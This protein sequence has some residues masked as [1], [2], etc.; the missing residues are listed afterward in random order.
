MTIF[1]GFVT[2]GTTGVKPAKPRF[3]PEN[4]GAIGEGL[5]RNDP[6]AI[7][8]A[9]MVLARAGNEEA[10]AG[11]EQKL[12]EHLLSAE[13]DAR[14]VAY[15]IRREDRQKVIYLALNSESKE[16]RMQI[17]RSLIHGLTSASDYKRGYFVDEL[18]KI[19]WN[20]TDKELRLFIMRTI[21]EINLNIAPHNKDDQTEYLTLLYANFDALVKGRK[22]DVIL[23]SSL[24][25]SA[26]EM[27]LVNYPDQKLICLEHLLRITLKRSGSI[28]GMI[29]SKL[30]EEGHINADDVRKAL[31]NIEALEVARIAD[32]Y[33]GRLV[34]PSKY[35]DNHQWLEIPQIERLK[36]DVEGFVNGDLT[37]ELLESRLKV[38]NA[39]ILCSEDKEL[40]LRIA[41]AVEKVI[42]NTK[43]DHP[44]MY[45]SFLVLRALG[46]K[47][48]DSLDR[49]KNE[50][51]FEEVRAR[52]REILARNISYCRIALPKTVEHFV[53]P[54]DDSYYRE[55]TRRNHLISDLSLLAASESADAQLL[56]LELTNRWDVI[57]GFEGV[58]SEFAKNSPHAEVRKKAL[59]AIEKAD[60]RYCHFDVN[61]PYE[62][63]GIISEGKYDDIFP[64]AIRIVGRFAR[65]GVRGYDDH[66]SSIVI[67]MSRAGLF[68]KP[69]LLK[70]ALEELRSLERRSTHDEAILAVHTES[71]QER[72]RITQKLAAPEHIG[73]GL[74]G[75]IR[76]GSQEQMTAI[77]K[78]L[79]EN[80]KRELVFRISRQLVLANSDRYPEEMV[81]AAQEAVGSTNPIEQVM[82]V[83]SLVVGGKT[84]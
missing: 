48:E 59:E 27:L 18:Q 11:L 15:F 8:K 73:E 79:I 71:E 34:L 38:L 10:K 7:Y 37:I 77:F 19:A 54:E 21:A 52:A 61:K 35:H 1:G 74:L 49:I 2:K 28:S 55:K 14:C 78:L 68:R 33:Y 22:G 44:K 80:G 64:E 76:T 53:N 30:N 20:S 42:A 46:F 57:G 43:F 23:H 24:R 50:P 70:I 51:K 32:P 39:Y 17:A 75:A 40:L 63:A 9:L 5:T 36:K 60:T 25:E 65:A 41:D 66:I 72:A 82:R 16:V 58:A 3:K 6:R 31:D 69:E 47:E 56:V 45:Y 83:L 62:L 4:I 81:K 67:M 84:G 26:F 29:L 12:F 13:A